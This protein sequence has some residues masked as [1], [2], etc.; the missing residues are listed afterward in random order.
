MRTRTG[1]RPGYRQ[2][3]AATPASLDL[4]EMPDYNVSLT[5]F[6]PYYLA[7]YLSLPS[8]TAVG[9]GTN[10]ARVFVCPAYD[11]ASPGN[12][13]AGYSPES[14]NYANAFCF[15]LSRTYNPPLSL[16]PGYPFGKGNQGE[17]PLK[18]SQIAAIVPLSEAWAVADFDWQQSA[19]RPATPDASLGVSKIPYI[20]MTPA[21][22]TVRTFL[23]FDFHVEARK[24]PGRRLLKSTIP[25]A[26]TGKE[27]I[28][29]VVTV[30]PAA[31]CLG[32]AA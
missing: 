15:S 30:I 9:N 27:I 2:Q 19:R 1:C 23:Y 24:S 16:L 3:N 13:Q 10:V 12:T 31:A 18:L 28:L 22:K 6:L 32:L 21:H 20:S 7:A 26:M 8:P 29:V 17:S 5:N 11:H 25:T 14:D 4:T